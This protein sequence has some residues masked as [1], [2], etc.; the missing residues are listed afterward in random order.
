MVRE[1]TESVVASDEAK[2]KSSASKKKDTQEDVEMEG[3]PDEEVDEEEEE[4]EVE[5]ILD[6]K[7]GAVTKVSLGITTKK[8]N[9]C[10]HPNLQGEWGYFVKWRG[11]GDEHNSWV[12]QKDA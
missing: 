6:A 3:A 12:D 8:R 4:Y 9:S 2:P 7:R 1:S 10:V 5:A 11:Y